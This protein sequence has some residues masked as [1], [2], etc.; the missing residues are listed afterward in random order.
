MDGNDETP[1]PNGMVWNM[2]FDENAP[3]GHLAEI[4]EQELWRRHDAFLREV[5]PVAEASGVVLALHPDDP[6]VERVRRQPRLVWRPDRYAR[7]LA[8]HPSPAWGLEFCV[9]TL[10]EMPDHDI[11]DTVALYAATGRIGYVH[12]RNVAGHAPHYRETFVDD[13]DVDLARVLRILH[14]HAFEGVVIPD[15]APQMTCAAPWHAGMAYAMGWMKRALD[16][17]Q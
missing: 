16:E 4:T 8:E 13:G 6:P 2:V 9:G 5:L 3:A 15:H 17:L 11:Y 14:E 12:L 7:L 10:A 1:I